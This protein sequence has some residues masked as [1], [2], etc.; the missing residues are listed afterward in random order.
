MIFNQYNLTSYN[1]VSKL[2][3]VIDSAIVLS[4]FLLS[5]ILW[6]H[7]VLFSE[8]ESV[9]DIHRFLM[10]LFPLDIQLPRGEERDSI[11]WFVDVT[12]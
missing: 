11:I 10:N 7:G 9:H 4:M 2:P 1:I 5:F 8:S 6:Y 12:S 3:L